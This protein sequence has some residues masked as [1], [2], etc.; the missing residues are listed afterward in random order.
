MIR[1]IIPLLMVLSIAGC[2]RF[3]S[4]QPG[5]TGGTTLEI[6]DKTYD[7]VWNAVVVAANHGRTIIESNKDLGTLKAEKVKG[8]TYGEIIGIWVQPT[9]DGAPVYTVLVQ[10]LKRDPLQL[11]DEDWTE[12]IISGIKTDLGQ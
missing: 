5:K 11:T 8:T 4:L 6:R 7:E 2:A 3:T 10:F 1:W 12:S 9:R